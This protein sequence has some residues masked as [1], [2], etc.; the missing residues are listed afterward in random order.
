MNLKNITKKIA[1]FGSGQPVFRP[2]IL[3]RGLGAVRKLL[4]QPHPRTPRIRPNPSDH[5][6]VRRRRAPPRPRRP[7]P[8][9]RRH[10]HAQ[11]PNRIDFIG[12]QHATLLMPWCSFTSATFHS[13]FASSRPTTRIPTGQPWP[14]QTP[15]TSS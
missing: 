4:M 8:A 7:H 14:P 1:C 2:M 9:T 11:A 12:K 10:R 15:E 6:P 3:N 5:P 13:H